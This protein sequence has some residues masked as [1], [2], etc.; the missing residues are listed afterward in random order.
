[1]FANFITYKNQEGHARVGHYDQDT[2]L[3]QPLALASGAPV[4][5]LYQVIEVGA[6]TLI[7]DGGPQLR[8][9]LLTLLP[10]LTGRDVLCVG[11]N[12]AEHAKE[13]N[14][15]GYDA[16]DK[17]DQPT[18]PVIFT[19][20]STSIIASGAD[21]LPLSHFTET[22]DYEGEIGVIIGT[23]GH[24][25]SEQHA[26]KH[27]WGYTIIND[28]TARERQRDHKQFYIGK[29]ADTF[30]PMGPIAKQKEQLPSCLTVQ[31]YVNG[32]KRQEGTTDDLIFSISKLIQTLSEGTTLRMGDVIATGTPA[33]VGFGLDPPQFLKPGDLVD[34][35]VT[36]LGTLWNR[37]ASAT[38]DNYVAVDTKLHDT[39]LKTYNLDRT[40]G[41][42]GLLKVNGKL[43]NIVKSGVAGGDRITYVHGLGG[44][45]EYWAPLISTL[46]LD[47]TH[48][49]VLL[50][51]EGHGL[52]PTAASSVITITSYAADLAAIFTKP[53]ILIAQGMGCLVALT[54][55]SAHP[56]LVTKLILIGPPPF[57]IPT[58]AREAHL[59]LAVSVRARGML[60]SGNVVGIADIGTSKKTKESKPLALSAV[61][62]F[63]LSQD[64]EGYAKGC[65]ALAG[66]TEELDMEPLRMPVLIVTGDENDGCTAEILAFYQRRLRDCRVEML[67]GVGHW[68]V[69]ED[70]DG[71]ALMVKSF[72]RS[73]VTGN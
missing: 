63:L 50:D 18:H 17:V 34:V 68:H 51:L 20:R 52:S 40:C 16:S 27:V 48:E 30:C 13:F 3:I 55:A 69:T 72:L 57:V 37:V 60:H 5:N 12:Y 11:K 29:S 31:T 59:K 66:A 4:E 35:T 7:P 6:D 64:P 53:S 14:R 56:D 44:S 24:Q 70:V 21:I 33:G 61:R 26:M 36:G 45:M 39:H 65:T 15:S 42:V 47:K 54:F 71:V 2:S 62:Q 43:L 41:G 10:P 32:S 25:I 9:D 28:V 22:L 58:A 38:S 8:L 73:G 67:N 1:M 19:K 49:N 23:S 46:Q